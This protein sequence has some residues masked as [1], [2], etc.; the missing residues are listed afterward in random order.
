M[1]KMDAAVYNTAWDLE[2]FSM[3]FRKIKTK[4][5]QTTG[6]KKGENLKS[7]SQR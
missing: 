7:Q 4:A 1:I 3:E 2:R 5:I 6:Q